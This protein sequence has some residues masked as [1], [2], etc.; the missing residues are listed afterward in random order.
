MSTAE[1][2][3]VFQRW[4][5]A[6]RRPYPL[7]ASGLP[8]CEIAR[9]IFMESDATPVF[10][11]KCE[12]CVAR[13]PVGAR[14]LT[15]AEWRYTTATRGIFAAHD[16]W[17]L[18][19]R[20]S[21]TSHVPWF[22]YASRPCPVCGGAGE[23]RAPVAVLLSGAADGDAAARDV[24]LT[25]ADQLLAEGNPLGALLSWTLLLWMREP[26]DLRHADEAVR[27]LEWLTAQHELV[28]NRGAG[29]LTYTVTIDGHDYS[30]PAR[31]SAAVDS[32]TAADVVAALNEQDGPATFHVNANGSIGYS[33]RT[34][35]SRSSVELLPPAAVE[36]PA[37]ER[38]RG[39][40]PHIGSHLGRR[41]GVR[42]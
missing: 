8:V 6:T 25:H 39:H 31:S 3:D 12:S 34:V 16:G 1:A 27:W 30:V 17:K 26:A 10:V 22:G 28:R 29:V 9:A 33:F 4:C 5:I 36:P 14:K 13:S 19:T 35:G 42:R 37:G 38:R 20:D 41:L 24:L 23:K 21:T 32:M 15:V 7:Y 40:A 11:G 18:E 2:L